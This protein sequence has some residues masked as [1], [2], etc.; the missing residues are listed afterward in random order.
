LKL[1]PQ[2]REQGTLFLVSMEALSER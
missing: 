2:R 1:T